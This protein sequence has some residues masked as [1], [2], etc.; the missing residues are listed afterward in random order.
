MACLPRLATGFTINCQ[1]EIILT[2]NT[3]GGVSA[4][5]VTNDSQAYKNAMLSRIIFLHA[6]QTELRVSFVLFILLAVYPSRN[7]RKVNAYNSSRFSC[8]RN[9]CYLEF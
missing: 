9:I 8:P 7:S 1:L 2:P 3:R 5:L 4:Q 6:V